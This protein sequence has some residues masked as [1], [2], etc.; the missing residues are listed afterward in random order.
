MIR[1]QVLVCVLQ[2]ILSTEPCAQLPS[3]SQHSKDGEALVK[4]G[5]PLTRP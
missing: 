4:L 5:N 3:L 1:T 2:A